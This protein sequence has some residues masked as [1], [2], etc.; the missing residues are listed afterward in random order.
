[1]A[2]WTAIMKVSSSTS[3]TNN[4]ITLAATSCFV[5][6]SGDRDVY[7]NT[8]T[9]FTEAT[10]VHIGSQ[11]DGSGEFD[12]G[13]E[14]HVSCAGNHCWYVRY[15]SASQFGYHGW[16]SVDSHTAVGIM[17]VTSNGGSTGT[18]DPYMDSY[19]TGSPRPYEGMCFKFDHGVNVEVDPITIHFGSGSAVTDDS[20]N[21]H[22]QM[23]ELATAYTY[24][25]GWSSPN[26]ASKLSLTTHQVAKT[27]HY[28]WIAVSLRPTAVA[29]HSQDRIKVEGTYF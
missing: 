17:S 14:H 13:V 8:I 7:F 25:D 18:D 26:P 29:F 15:D 21:C 24:S 4:T 2:T 1:M 6:G 20:E 22:L 5:Y 19:K 12:T 9:V 16:A 3:V 11:E 27:G 28:W 23:M 10:N